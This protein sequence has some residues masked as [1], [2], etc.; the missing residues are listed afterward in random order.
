MVTNIWRRRL[1]KT[2]I[3]AGICFFAA[4]LCFFPRQTAQSA[5]D[6]LGVCLT[7]LIPSLF[8]FFAVSAFAVSCGAARDIGRLFEKPVRWLFNVPGA[9]A[10]AF[11]L[12]LIGGY[13]VGAKTAIGLYEQKLCSKTECE[14]L[15]AFCNNSG[16]AFIL[17]VAGL[18]VFGTARAGVL[19]YGAHVLASVLVGLVFRFYGRDF[20]YSRR[21]RASDQVAARACP[22]RGANA[23]K[24]AERRHPKRFSLLF[25]RRLWLSLQ[26]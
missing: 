7:V 18:S 19:L 4:G 17:G 6:A 15:L 24:K 25:C 26:P 20:S 5:S 16:P 13:P 21:T 3:Y 9:C 2:Q 23:G 14:R 10:S 22:R 12:G 11:I 8:P 1:F